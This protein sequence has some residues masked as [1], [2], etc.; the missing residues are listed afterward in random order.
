MQYLPK[1]TSE[2]ERTS[3]TF[4]P[5]ALRKRGVYMHFIPV[6]LYDGSPEHSQQE[7]ST[8]SKY[9][10]REFSLYAAFN[11]SENW[12]SLCYDRFKR[13]QKVRLSLIGNTCV[14]CVFRV[15]YILCFSFFSSHAAHKLPYYHSV[16]LYQSYRFGYG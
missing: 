11:A 15:Q 9:L 2:V 4:G 10:L 12:K 13:L 1:Y 3:P 14:Y 8:F 5:R 6:S 16:R 7:S